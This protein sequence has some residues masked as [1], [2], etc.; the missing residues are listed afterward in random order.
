MIRSTKR[1]R[2]PEIRDEGSLDRISSLPDELIGHIL[3]F[4]PT[5]SA[6]QTSLLSTRWKY[7][8]TLTTSLSFDD[9]EYFDF[10]G[11]KTVNTAF[12][13]FVSGV[14]TVHRVMSI[15]KFSLKLKRTCDYACSDFLLWI[16]IAILKGVRHLNLYI[17]Y[18]QISLPNCILCSQNLVALQINSVIHKVDLKVPML[19]C[20]PSLRVCK[21]CKV[22]FL[23]AESIKRFFVG[24]PQLKELILLHCQLAAD[25]FQIS[26]LA[27]EKLTVYLCRGHMEI[28]APNLASLSYLCTCSDVMTLLLKK[29]CSPSTVHVG[30]HSYEF[31]GPLSQH[32]LNLIIGAQNARELILTLNAPKLLI[33]L[34]D[35]QIPTYSKLESLH[36]DFCCKDTW[37]YVTFW[38]ANS[39]QL[40]TIVFNM[41]LLHAATCGT[42][43][44]HKWRPSMELAPFSSNVK[45][46]EVHQF[47]GGKTELLL[48]NYLL[49]NAR[50]LKRLILFKYGSMTIE[51]ELQVSKELLMLPKTSTHCTIE[52]K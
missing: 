36:L 21:L 1:R 8:F 31:H 25:H 18:Q 41:G 44:E 33:R 14:L 29:S 50:A 34:D 2:V 15:Q 23:D 16:N 6:L 11:I 30:F 5:L 12:E 9:Q 26:A 17:S 46:I 10:H 45:I 37:K 4:L 3:S 51:E 32:V 42:E 24:C 39:P 49:E 38:L 28:D 27:L 22:T 40:E 20:L 35:N 52:L 7:L 47:K 19:V 48:L 13:K 43:Q